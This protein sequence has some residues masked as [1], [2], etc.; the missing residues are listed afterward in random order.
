M[1]TIAARGMSET[2]DLFLLSE[3]FVE[4]FKKIIDAESH[5]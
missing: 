1:V 4:G 2:R 3:N 5:T